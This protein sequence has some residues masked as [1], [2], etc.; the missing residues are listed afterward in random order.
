MEQLRVKLAGDSPLMTHN[1]RLANPLGPYA[2]ALKLLTGKRNKTDAD[3][4]EIAR[5]EWEGGLYLEG[6]VVV[7]PSR[8]LNA[9]FFEGAKKKKNGPKW[10]TGAIIDG[11]SF[12]L[13]YKGPKIKVE[14]NGD[15]PNPALDKYYSHYVSQEMVKVGTSSI[16][17]TRPVFMDWSLEATI[18]YD[19]NI[20]DPRTLMQIFE[21]GGYLIGLCERRPGSKGGGTLGRFKVEKV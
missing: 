13:C 15:I 3:L 6:G 17:R 5:L 7:M 21:D 2:K 10:R 16:L 12:P 20:L 9:C 18:L 11:E 1:I 8:C 4:Q 14:T 19:E